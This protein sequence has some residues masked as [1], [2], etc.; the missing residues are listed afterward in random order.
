MANQVIVFPDARTIAINYVRAALVARGE[1]TVKVQSR[2]PT[3]ND[4]D[5]VRIFRTG[6]V[7]TLVTDDAQLTIEVYALT[8][9]RAHDLA[10]L[11]RALLKAARGTVQGGVTVYGVNEFTGPNEF[12]DPITEKPRYSWSIHFS[13]RGAAS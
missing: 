4:R 2:I 8:D 6:G 7:S 5:L 10:Q 13:V 1:T 3:P 12:P 11:V 9:V